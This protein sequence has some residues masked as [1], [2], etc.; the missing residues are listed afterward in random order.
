MTVEVR[1]AAAFM[2]AYWDGYPAALKACAELCGRD[3]GA[4]RGV[5]ARAWA[6]RDAR[7]LA[8]SAEALAASGDLDPDLCLKAGIALYVHD[9]PDQQLRFLTDPVLKHLRAAKG[10]FHLGR[11]LAAAGRRAEARAAFEEATAQRAELAAAVHLVAALDEADRL[12]A[13]AAGSSD[14]SDHRRQLDAVLGLRDRGEAAAIARRAL[15]LPIPRKRNRMLDLCRVLDVGLDC[16]LDVQAVAG[17]LHAARRVHAEDANVRAL[18]LDCEVLAGRAQDALQAAAAEPPPDDAY[19]DDSWGYALA[20]ARL[21]A[22]QAREAALAFGELTLTHPRGQE[23]RSSLAHA[24][25]AAVL[26]ETPPRKPAARRARRIISVFPFNDEV[27][28]LKIRLHEMAGWVDSFVLVEAAQTFVGNPKP[29]HFQERR[30]EFAAFESQ[31]VHVTVE[32]FPDHVRTH[33]ARDFHQRDAAWPALAELCG[34]EDLVL[35]TD[36]DEIVDR[37]A[38]EGFDGDFARLHMPLHRFFLNYRPAAPSQLLNGR[39]GAV[40]KGGLLRG[41]GLSYARF[42]LSRLEKDWA[43][44]QDAGWHFSSLGDA[45]RIARKYANYA[46]QEAGK[47]LELLRERDSVEVLLDEIK[48]GRREDGWERCEIDDSYPAYVR[49]HQEDLTALIL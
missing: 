41:W 1:R 34:D 19:R 42:C 27:T 40:W 49:E 21:E 30:A 12:A 48:A 43:R 3:P 25:G 24:V 11:A 9:R 2:R 44:I 6:V 13:I 31:I 45:E 47:G 22:G 8:A 7:R 23:M 32:R 18:E 39:A 10:M 33:W 16:G 28:L 35:V 36:V 46:H 5:A 14:W 26:Q 17:V 38:L 20:N 37:R 15:D 4:L 29:L